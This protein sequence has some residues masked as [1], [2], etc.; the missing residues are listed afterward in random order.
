MRW[1]ENNKLQIRYRDLV[2]N[3]LPNDIYRITEIKQ[4]RE[5]QTKTIQKMTTILSVKKVKIGSVGVD[6]I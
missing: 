3:V 1:Y 4:N 6:Q 5:N 2:T